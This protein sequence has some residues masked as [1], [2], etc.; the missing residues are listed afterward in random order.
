MPTPAFVPDRLP[1]KWQLPNDL[2]QLCM[3]A[4]EELARLDGGGKHLQ[5]YFLLLTPLK[6]MEALRS[7]S[8]EGTFATP[9]E[10]LMYDLDHDTTQQGNERSGEMREVFNYHEALDL[11]MEAI[12]DGQE[13]TLQ[14][15]RALHERLLVGTRGE[16]KDPGNFRKIQVLVGVG[17][18]YVPPPPSMVISCL[19]DFE[20]HQRAPADTLEID[21][22]VRCFLAHY[23][24]ETI[25]PFKDGNGRV[26]RLLLAISVYKWLGLSKPWLYMSTYF[27]KHKNDYID[28][29][30]EVSTKG[31][32]HNW[33][34]FCLQGVKEQAVDSMARIHAILELRQSYTDKIR[35][36]GGSVR[37]SEISDSLFTS[38][39][40]SI[41]QI[42]DQF[43]V[44]YPTAKKDIEILISLGMLNKTKVK[45]RNS[46]LFIASEIVSISYGYD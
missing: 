16:A 46:T 45:Y 32:W 5:D 43:H 44:T 21:P 37:L 29:M 42:R 30:F 11:G 4:R 25:H 36:H 9:E 41:P 39:V 22:L 13:L 27:E 7:S 19:A 2:V 3:S 17:G 33:I 14:F 23:Q 20:E 12:D 35:N 31:N 15:I 40:I 8:I 10:L 6:K 26:G 34:E 38:Q 28:L 18:R 1:V 24:F